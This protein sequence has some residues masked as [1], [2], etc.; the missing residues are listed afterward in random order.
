MFTP[1]P[2]RTSTS[3]LQRPWAGQSIPSADLCRMRDKGNRTALNLQ[4]KA[5]LTGPGTCRKYL[6]KTC[7]AAPSLGQ[8][9]HSSP[10]SRKHENRWQLIYITEVWSCVWFSIIVLFH[11]LLR[12]ITNNVCLSMWQK[13]YPNCARCRAPLTWGKGNR[14][15]RYSS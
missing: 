1:T 4:L 6:E 3:A 13:K 14:Q 7:L 12:E 10:Q 9:G 5:E 2:L 8:L 15:S 11:K